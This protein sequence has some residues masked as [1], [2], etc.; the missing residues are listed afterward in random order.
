MKANPGLIKL[1]SQ[2]A[3][4]PEYYCDN[5]N[6]HRYSPCTCKVGKNKKEK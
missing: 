4:K 6:C 2:T 5:C 1:R 3:K